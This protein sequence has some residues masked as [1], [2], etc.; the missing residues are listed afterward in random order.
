[1]TASPAVLAIEEKMTE[2]ATIQSEA[3]TKRRS[4]GQERKVV[5][6]EEAETSIGHVIALANDGQLEDPRDPEHRSVTGF[7]PNEVAAYIWYAHVFEKHEEE[8]TARLACELL[9][10]RVDVNVSRYPVA[11]AG[12]DMPAEIIAGGMRVYVRVYREQRL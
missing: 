2:Q 9:D 7:D 3:R 11:V 8:Q 10:Y 4:Y 12:V 6:L 1:M 5:R